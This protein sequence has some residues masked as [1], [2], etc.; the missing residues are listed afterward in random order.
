M[1]LCRACLLVAGLAAALAA[2]GCRRDPR[3][4]I[5]LDVFDLVDRYYVEKVDRRE[6]TADAFAGLIDRL[7]KDVQNGAQ[8]ALIKEF[9][10]ARERGEDPTPPGFFQEDKEVS[11][12]P[13]PTP[14]DNVE[15]QASPTRVAIKAG[16]D[17]FARNLPA[18]K[19]KLAQIILDGV[20]FCKTALRLTQSR[21][22]LLHMALDAM[23]YRLDPHSGFLDLGDYKN[24]QQ[25]TQGSFGGVGVEIGLRKGLLVVIAPLEGSPAAKA[26][27]ESQDRIVAIE[28]EDTLGQT[29]EWAVRRIRG[30]I[31]TAVLLTVKRAG[32]PDAFEVSLVRDKIEAVAVRSKLLPG[33]IGWVRLIQFNARIED[34]MDKAIQELETASGGLRALILDLRNDPGGL[35]DQAVAVSDRFLSSGLIVDTI[36]RGYLQERERFASGHGP[37]TKVPMVTLVNGGSASAAEIVAGALK[38]HERALVLG[39]QTFGKGSVQSIFELP[40]E[41]GLRLTTAMYYTPS[42]ASIQE[43]GITPHIRLRPPHEDVDPYYSEARM[44]HHRKNQTRAQPPAPNLEIDAKALF[45]YAMAKRWIKKEVDEYSDYP[46]DNDMVLALATRLLVGDDLSIPALISR[47]KDIDALLPHEK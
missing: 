9:L 21:D 39:Y 43:F 8:E 18:D 12:T 44:E 2:P 16:G 25:E 35:L 7:K 45:D 31:G 47:A 23:M 28:H 33:R 29:L 11:P 38:D 42:G 10:Q 24:L 20:D 6:L 15:V 46:A 34:D 5:I 27:L 40:N 13:I 30:K 41:N 14:Y 36:G 17:A 19:R 1:A 3:Q 26:G 32:R 22:D 4:T 37:W